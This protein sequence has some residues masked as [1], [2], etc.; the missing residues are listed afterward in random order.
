MIARVLVLFFFLVM[1]GACTDAH[2]ADDGNGNNR[3][4]EDDDSEEGAGSEDRD[5]GT[6]RGNPGAGADGGSTPGSGN[7]GSSGGGTGEPVFDDVSSCQPC[8]GAEG[9]MGPLEPCCTADGECGLD[10]GA[11]NGLGPTCAQQ[12]APGTQSM[13]CPAYMFGQNF[14]LTS[15]C[16]AGGVCGVMI[17]MTAPLGCVDPRLLGDLVS[18]ADAAGGGEPPGCGGNAD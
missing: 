3:R 14:D 1:P 12:N 11:I 9:S 6:G 10:I 16:G 2:D 8:E 17:V 18:P 13:S 5:G 15:C 4:D 7:S